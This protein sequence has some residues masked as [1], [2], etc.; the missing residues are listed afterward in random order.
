MHL[1]LAA[2]LPEMKASRYFFG[3]P[4]AGSPHFAVFEGGFVSREEKA[5]AFSSPESQAVPVDE[6]NFVTGGALAVDGE[7]AT[8]P[9]Q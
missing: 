6:P 1:P 9:G 5:A 8:L 7:V 4:G 3:V 2:T